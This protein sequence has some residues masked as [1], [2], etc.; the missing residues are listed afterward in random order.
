MAFIVLIYPWPA[1]LERV[2]LP[3]PSAPRLEQTGRD[4]RT[5]RSDTNLRLNSARVCFSG[6]ERDKGDPALTDR[7]DQAW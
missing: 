6:R 4:E 1:S 3:T 2:R 7:L 5:A